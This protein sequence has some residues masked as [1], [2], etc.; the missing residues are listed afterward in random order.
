[1][2]PGMIIHTT[3]VSVGIQNIDKARPPLLNIGQGTALVVSTPPVIL[4]QVK[5]NHVEM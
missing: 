1:M 2:L 5:G 4:C 3:L